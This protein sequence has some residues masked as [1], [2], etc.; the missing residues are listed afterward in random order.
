[1]NRTARSLP[2]LAIAV[3]ILIVLASS[4][5]AQSPVYVTGG[6]F[7]DIRQFGS[8]N[9]TYYGDALDF[10]LDATGA[11]GGLRIGTFL[12][13]RWSVEL[14]LDVGTSTT[15]DAPDPYVILAIYAP[16][17][18]PYPD[19]KTSTSFLTVSTV[20]GFHPPP[21][22]R[23][24][25]GYRGGF[26]FVRGT[27]K[28]DYPD[29]GV[30]AAFSRT[31]STTLPT[32]PPVTRFDPLPTIFPAPRFQVST[33]TQNHLAGA[34]ILGFEAAIDITS[35]LAIVPEIRALAFSTPNNGPGVF[36]VRPGVGVRWGF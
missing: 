3:G 13:P 12:H 5:A 19:L 25:L 1:M 20:V 8:T 7:S 22:G 18:L 16:F 21:H 15:V 32:S 9:D 14:G 35:H 33:L 30:L 28:S 11:G 24:R 27:Y 26:G 31:T 29:Y 23:V 36:L 17:P 6:A 34:V 10:S 4:A 2:T